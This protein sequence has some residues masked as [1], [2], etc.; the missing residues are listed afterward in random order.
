[1]GTDKGQSRKREAGTKNG[2]KKPKTGG[3]EGYGEQ[4][5]TQPPKALEETSQSK[6][7]ANKGRKHHETRAKGREAEG[8]EHRVRTCKQNPK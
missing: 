4:K 7:A 3:A 8:G 6:E 5:T 2:S 1:M